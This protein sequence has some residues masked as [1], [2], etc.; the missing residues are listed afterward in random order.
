MTEQW[1]YADVARHLNVTPATVRKYAALG[2]LPDPDGKV[3]QSPWWWPDT[4][5]TWHASRPGRGVGGG[6]PRKPTP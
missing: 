5:R 4:I 3:A 2:M 6:R 1:S